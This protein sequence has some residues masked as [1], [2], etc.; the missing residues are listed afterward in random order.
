MSYPK[1]CAL[2]ATS[3]SNCRHPPGTEHDPRGLTSRTEPSASVAV[4][5]SYP[6]TEAKSAGTAQ[7]L[8]EVPALLGGAATVRATATPSTSVAA[9][10][11]QR[12]DFLGGLG[13]P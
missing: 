10:D 5:G 12:I 8:S 13:K 11:I 9:R 7:V 3:K 6:I 2:Q 1:S 4:T